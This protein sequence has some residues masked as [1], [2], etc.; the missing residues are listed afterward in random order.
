VK[1]KYVIDQ[2]TLLAADEQETNISKRMMEW[3]REMKVH[4]SGT[5]IHKCKLQ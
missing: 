2:S 4:S 3:K 1:K 5:S